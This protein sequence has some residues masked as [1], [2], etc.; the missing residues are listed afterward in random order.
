MGC[1]APISEKS[2][3]LFWMY[4]GIYQKSFWMCLGSAQQ[5]LSNFIKR[6]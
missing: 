6:A 3:L 4:V 5:K 2:K 1:Q